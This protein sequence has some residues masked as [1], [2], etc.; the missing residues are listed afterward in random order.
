MLDLVEGGSLNSGCQF[1]N[2]ADSFNLISIERKGMEARC[3]HA[4]IQSLV[5]NP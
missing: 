5:Q 2:M 3:V 1:D 4:H